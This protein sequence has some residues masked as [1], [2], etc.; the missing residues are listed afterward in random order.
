MN[1]GTIKTIKRDSV[2][3][4]I[5]CVPWWWDN[6]DFNCDIGKKLLVYRGICNTVD[7]VKI[8]LWIV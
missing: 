3:N 1:K 4:T 5:I 8:S 2:F 7:S 6:K